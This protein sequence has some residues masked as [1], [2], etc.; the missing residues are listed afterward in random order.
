[1]ANANGNNA[2]EK[3]VL[4]N[5]KSETRAVHRT[6]SLFCKAFQDFSATLLFWTETKNPPEFLKFSRKKNDDDDSFA[7]F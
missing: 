5:F 1:M 2:L 7:S 4:T 6:E 3:S